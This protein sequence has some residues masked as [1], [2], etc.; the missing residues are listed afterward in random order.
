MHVLVTFGNGRGLLFMSFHTIVQ[1]FACVPYIACITQV[2]LEVIKYT[3]FIYD[4]WLCFFQ[5]FLKHIHVSDFSKISS[6][7]DTREALDTG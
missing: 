3:L 5:E 1:M 7:V 6:S 2:T 4:R